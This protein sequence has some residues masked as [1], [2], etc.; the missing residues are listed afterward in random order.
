MTGYS[1]TDSH[2]CILSCLSGG[3]MNRHMRNAALFLTIVFT[4]VQLVTPQSGAQVAWPTPHEG[5]FTIHNF[6]FQSG[7]TLP[8]VRMHYTTLGT[9]I[10]DATGH[11]TNA[12]LVLHA[13]G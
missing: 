6:H 8:E 9:P 1:E 4:N 12:V 10:R 11:T 13:P 3:A 5:D 2:R 7:E